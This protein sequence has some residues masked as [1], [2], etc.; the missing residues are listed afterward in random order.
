M[1]KRVYD[2]E[3]LEKI[4]NRYI[5]EEKYG[6]FKPLLNEIFLRRAYEFGFDDRQMKKQ[7]KNFVKK[8]DKIYFGINISKEDEDTLGIYY[9]RTKHIYINCEHRDFKKDCID[10]LEMYE[11][12]T[13][14]TYHAISKGL[15]IETNNPNV[16]I[17]DPKGMILLADAEEQDGEAAN[18]IWT[19]TA[20]NR[21]SYKRTQED[22]ER[23]R[24]NTNG[25]SNITFLVNLLS[26]SFGIKE[27]EILKAG[28]R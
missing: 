27:R 25:Y 26:A 20:A 6:G 12:L 14:E 16:A 28:I 10:Y 2:N 5:K 4:L 1:E 9:S 22:D 21:T 7:I 3:K 19:E 17:V 13:H 23:F 11:V 8:I 18:E 24:A 15:K